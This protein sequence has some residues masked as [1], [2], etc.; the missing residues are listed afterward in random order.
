LALIKEISLI[1]KF[2]LNTFMK[3]C[4]IFRRERTDVKKNRKF[5]GHI[6][7][8]IRKGINDSFGY[9]SIK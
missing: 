3:K 1:L 8:R 4:F 5:T 9:I 6:N 7:K 2:K